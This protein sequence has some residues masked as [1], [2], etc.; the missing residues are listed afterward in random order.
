MGSVALTVGADT[1][2]LD[3]YE[4]PPDILFY[5]SR[6]LVTRTKPFAGFPSQISEL[7]RPQP[8]LRITQ[9]CQVYDHLGISEIEHDPKRRSDLLIARA[10]RAVNHMVQTGLGTAWLTSLPYAVAVPILEMIR[11]CQNTPE[12]TWSIDVF[13]FIGRSDLAMQRQGLILPDEGDVEEVSQKVG[14]RAKSPIA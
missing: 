11:V 6:R 7:G 1:S 12:K 3:G 9:V 14:N 8:L 4:T 2:C 13:H 5:L 10:S